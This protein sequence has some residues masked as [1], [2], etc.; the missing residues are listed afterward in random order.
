MRTMLLIAAASLAA[1]GSAP[2]T[3][4]AGDFVIVNGTTGAISGLSIRRFGTQE[5]KQL[6]GAAAA[7]AR[8]PVTF[9]DPDCAFDIRGT[10]AGA[11]E[12]VWSGIN[13]CGAKSVILNRNPSGEAWAD[14]E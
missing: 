4:G 12:S 10:V 1:L 6:S 13:L 8:S 11:G 9:S 14:Y 3:A 5:W 2:A 7:G